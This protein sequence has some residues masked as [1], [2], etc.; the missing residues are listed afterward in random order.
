MKP[1]AAML[2]LALLLQGSPAEEYKARHE[3]LLKNTAAKHYA[4]GDYLA[5]A[6][7]HAWARTEFRRVID[8]LDPDHE[9][10]R[11]RLGYRKN[12]QGQWEDDPNAK[13]DVGNRK[14]GEDAAKVQK[15]WN[16]R[17]EQ[18][19][20]DLS[21]QWSDLALWCKKNVLQKEADGAFRKALEYDP[22]NATARK[23]LGYEKLGKSGVWISKFERELR[24]EMK[25]GIAKAPQGTASS[26]ASE[27]EPALGIKLK[28]RE[29]GHIVLESPHLSDADL[30]SLVQHCE[31]AYAMYHKI[32]GQEDLFG[33]LKMTHVILKDKVQH[34]R[35]IDAFQKGRSPQEIELS[36]KATGS[37][38]FP[39]SEQY[40]DTRPIESI[41]DMAVHST[42]QM[43]SNLLARGEHHWL[44][45]GTSYHFTRLMKD[46]AATYCVDLAGTSPQNRGKNYQ[47]PDDWPVVCKVWVREDK[48]P[49][50]LAILKC[51]NVQELDGAETVKAWSL[52]EFLI[53]EHRDKFIEVCKALGQGADVEKAFK[54]VFDWS[55]ETLDRRWKAYVKASY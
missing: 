43:L 30:V 24:K 12:D 2:G 25:D 42:V 35:Y 40:Q 41:Q 17:V 51:T 1:A 3:K 7:M 18:A 23:E 31:H 33:G 27:L 4:I 38:G 5:T 20:K 19:G 28:R 55:V 53:T 29:A 44:H 13:Q 9:G 22:G 34:E 11:K 52:V 50:M 8:D 26:A 6:Q 10:A 49:E 32:F 21:R 36:K 15:S 39:R 47:D 48:D 14:K 37:M 54:Q 46:T 16:E 45:E